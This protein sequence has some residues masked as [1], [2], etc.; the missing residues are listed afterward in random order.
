MH[1]L[2]D[3]FLIPGM[4]VESPRFSSNTCA[5]SRARNLVMADPRSSLCN[6]FAITPMRQLAR[7]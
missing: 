6:R 7:V 3:G 1:Q 4:P 5:E 2:L